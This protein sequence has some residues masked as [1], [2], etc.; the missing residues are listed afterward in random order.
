M[1]IGKGESK[2]KFS[3]EYIKVQNPNLAFEKIYPNS[4]FEPNSQT[5]RVRFRI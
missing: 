3:K 5:S 2:S 1:K 4:G